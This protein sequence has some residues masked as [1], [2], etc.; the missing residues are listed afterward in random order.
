MSEIVSINDYQTVLLQ[1]DALVMLGEALAPKP[2]PVKDKDNKDNSLI[3]E[4]GDDNNYPQWVLEQTSDVTLVEPILDWKARALY[5]G[6]IAYGKLITV[7][8]EE[9]FERIVDSEIEEWAENTDLDTYLRTASINFYTFY[10]IFPEL[11]QSKT[12]QYITYLACKD[13]GDCRYGK[14]NEKGVIQKLYVSPDWEQYDAKDPKTEPYDVFSHFYTDLKKWREKPN[15]Q[16][17]YPVASPS[18]GRAYYQKAP[19]HVILKT[20]LPIARAVPEFKK[21]LLKNQLTLKYIIKVPEWWWTWKYKDWESKSTNDRLTIIRKEKSDFEKFFKGDKQGNSMMYTQRDDSHS[22]KYG[23]WEVVVI[24]DKMKTGT[25]IEDSQEADAHIFKNMGVDS[26]LFGNGTGKDRSGGGS[27]SDKRVAW[28]N[29][30]IMTKPHQDLILKPLH[31][32]SRF[33]GW[34]DRLAPK[35]NEKLVFWF[36]NYQIAKLDS[37][38]ETE[39]NNSQKPSS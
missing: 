19:W 29:Y 4:W 31:F 9:R 23:D 6:G 1:N 37:G 14:K 15:H 34:Q 27:G 26:T 17:I 24:D 35:E 7:D 5:G 16:F 18:P 28:N 38:K 22:K 25:Y 3:E 13:T 39:E 2:R 10:N 20:W 12:G 36:K 21:A 30:M 11:S 8:G 32:I 33:N